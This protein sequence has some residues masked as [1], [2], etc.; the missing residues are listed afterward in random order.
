[1]PLVGK[2]VLQV[3]PEL[4]AGGAERTTLEVAQALVTAGATALVASTGGRLEGELA[5]LGGELIRLPL[6][7]KNPLTIHANAD[8]LARLI[9]ER[10]INIVHA[11]S[12][13]P[14]WSALWAAR[15]TEAAFVTTYHGT[16]NARSGLKRLYNSVMARG[17]LVIA[18][19]G[20][21]A[22]HVRAQHHTPPE[23]IVTIPRGVDPAQFAPEAISA[24]RCSA[25]RSHLSLPE[26]TT[27]PV[28]VLPARLT[29]W[30]GQEEFIDAL[31]EVKAHGLQF[32]ARLVG[33]AQGRDAYVAALQARIARHGLSERVAICPHT[34]DMPALLAV[35]DIIVSPAREPE[36]FGRVAIEAAASGRPVIVSDHG[37]ARETVVQGVTGLRVE[38]GSVSALAEAL[39]HLLQ[40]TPQARDA[41][42]QAGRTHV[43]AHF[44]V[45][46]LQAA[47]LGVY[48]RVLEARA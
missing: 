5:R 35:S 22:A 43:S 12:R 23:R 30:K 4:S 20:F 27:P 6:A 11:R 41:M 1:M 29:G 28:L 34:A 38:P 36:A 10:G 37:G 8:R 2:V 18:N 42:G 15:R 25:A 3:I 46:A 7:S 19:S 32:V 33:D 39:A 44:T 17:D 26:G 21:I 13:A 24:A 31:A 16:Y 14:A 47:T 45:A 48:T 40:M 9:R